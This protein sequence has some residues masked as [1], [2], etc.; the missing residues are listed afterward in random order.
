MNPM[1]GCLEQSGA[2]CQ[3]IKD[4]SEPL[5]QA[6]VS[7]SGILCSREPPAACAILMQIDL[8]AHRD[9]AKIGRFAVHQSS[10]QQR[11]CAH[12][13][14]VCLFAPSL[15]RLDSDLDRSNFFPSK[16]AF[17]APAL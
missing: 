9:W 10:L 13:P 3:L 11:V 2:Y 14:P 17:V 12:S 8:S 1:P 15:A 7:R 5:E 16:S 6:I 4:K